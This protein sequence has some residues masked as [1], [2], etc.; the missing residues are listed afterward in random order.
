MSIQ[1]VDGNSSWTHFLK[2]SNQARVRNAGFD[3]P[4][5]PQRNIS[6][7]KGKNAFHEAINGMPRAGKLYSKES[8]SQKKKAMLGTAFDAYA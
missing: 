4:L 1:S 3:L 7:A 8:T 6:S 5:T 2:L